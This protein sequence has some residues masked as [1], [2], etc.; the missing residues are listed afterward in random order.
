VCMYVLISP[1]TFPLSP[2][3]LPICPNGL[4]ISPLTFPYGTS[5]ISLEGLP[6][7][8]G[9]PLTCPIRLAHIGY[10]TVYPYRVPWYIWKHC[11]TKYGKVACPPTYQP[12]C[13]KRKEGEDYLWRERVSHLP[14]PRAKNTRPPIGC[15]AVPHSC[16]AAKAKDISP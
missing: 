6:P 2:N 15:V 5:R 3:G 4:P 11:M 9:V 14:Q 12:T 1:L 13:P 8:I 16:A 7:P 10:P